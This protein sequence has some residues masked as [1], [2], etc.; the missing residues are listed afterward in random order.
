MTSAPTMSPA[1]IVSVVIVEDH[2][3]VA[4]GLRQALE[5]SGITVLAIAHRV[6]TVKHV[7]G[8]NQPDVVLMDYALPDGDG[9]S[10]TRLV[11]EASPETRVIMLTGAGD[12]RVLVQAMTAGCAGY[13][14]KDQ[15]IADLVAAVRAAKNGATL[16]S[17][18]TLQRLIQHLGSGVPWIGSELSAR[19]VE[20]LQLFA[21][22]WANKEIARDLSLS[23]HTVR[24][25]VRSVLSKLGAHSKLEAVAVAQR[26]GILRI[27]GRSDGAFASSSSDAAASNPDGGQAGR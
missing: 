25:H 13:V 11:L 20:V 12:N 14:R 18:T 4:E 21:E 27:P 1:G 26:E 7:V 3:M 17:P 22:G 9:V 2:E 8:L 23:V 15:P 16:I 5:A 10:A 24:N 19:E 6:A